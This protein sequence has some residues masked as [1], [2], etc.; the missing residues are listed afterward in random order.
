VY[1][2]R[3]SELSSRE[4]EAEDEAAW[5]EMAEG[6]GKCNGLT[7]CHFI[8]TLTATSMYKCRK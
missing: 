5:T 1:H 8:N 4:I 2:K 7:T 3:A 6:T